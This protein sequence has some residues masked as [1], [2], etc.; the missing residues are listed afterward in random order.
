MG[1]RFGTDGVRGVANEYSM[2]AGPLCKGGGRS[3]GKKGDGITSI[4]R[5]RHLLS[6]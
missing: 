6:L 1:K 5:H 3:L 2:T 4:T